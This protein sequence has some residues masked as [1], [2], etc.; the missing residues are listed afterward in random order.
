MKTLDVGVIL[1]GMALYSRLVPSQARTTD[2]VL[3]LLMNYPAERRVLGVTVGDV[4]RDHSDRL[5]NPSSVLAAVDLLSEEGIVSVEKHTGLNDYRDATR[6]YLQLM[7]EIPP[8]DDAVLRETHAV[9]EYNVIVDFYKAADG[10]FFVWPY[11]QQMRGDGMSAKH[12]QI[13]GHFDSVDDAR[14]CA[15]TVGRTLVEVGFDIHSN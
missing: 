3:A 4:M 5:T 13:R 11:I 10:K 14:E 7:R 9:G 1:V 2:Q 15:L 6:I 8:T 12:F